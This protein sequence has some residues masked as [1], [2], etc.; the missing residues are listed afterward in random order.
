M[1]DGE[2]CGGVSES[3]TN[4]FRVTRNLSWIAAISAGLPQFV[5]VFS[6]VSLVLHPQHIEN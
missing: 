4:W 1:P 5:F 2:G 3:L 6:A